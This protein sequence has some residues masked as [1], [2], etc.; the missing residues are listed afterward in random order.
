MGK[1]SSF[2]KEECNI[3]GGHIDDLSATDE[4]KEEESDAYSCG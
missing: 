4:K 2:G 1:F 3:E